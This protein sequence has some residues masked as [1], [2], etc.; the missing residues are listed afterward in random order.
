MSEMR[1][2]CRVLATGGTYDINSN[3][4][5]LAVVLRIEGRWAE[6]EE[7]KSQEAIAKI[8]ARDNGA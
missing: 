8:Q 3:G 5:T 6:V 1:S 7:V 2:H 4:L